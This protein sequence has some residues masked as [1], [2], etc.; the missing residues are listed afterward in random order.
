MARA[1]ARL[2]LWLARVP[3][4]VRGLEHLPAEGGYVVASNHASYPDSLVLGALLPVNLSYVAK[5]ELRGHWISRIFLRR[6]D[7]EFV[8]R[9]DVQQGR[10]DAERIAAGMGRGRRLMFYPE[11]TFT[12]AP[13]LR[14]FHL[15]AF[16]AAVA[17]GVPVVPLVLRGTRSFLRDEQWLPRRAQI[18]VQLF[19]PIAPDGDDFAAAIRLR[20]AVRAVLL[21]HCGEPDLAEQA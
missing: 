10:G 2:V 8:E 3:V 11:G 16:R 17:G 9:F 6:L 12:R 14:P 20:D 13:G 1:G 19:P 21:A 5:G 18:T 7:T 4:R 15:G